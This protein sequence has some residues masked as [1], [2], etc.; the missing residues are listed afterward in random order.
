MMMASSYPDA[1]QEGIRQTDDL[2]TTTTTTTTPR[3]APHSAQTDIHNSTVQRDG[4]GINC[5]T[6]DREQPVTRPATCE[7]R[8]AGPGS[9]LRQLPP[10][11]IN[12]INLAPT[13]EESHQVKTHRHSASSH[14]SL[15]HPVATPIP[16]PIPSPSPSPSPI[17]IPIP[18]RSKS[19]S[20]PTTPLTARV[21]EG[22]YF[23]SNYYMTPRKPHFP[24]SSGGVSQRRDTRPT[25]DVDSSPPLAK[26]CS[27]GTS[28]NMRPGQDSLM[29][30]PTSPLSPIIPA[31]LVPS[32]HKTHAS[33][34]RT[35]R[36]PNLKLNSL[37][38]FHPA[39]FP[40]NDSSSASP[41]AS[42]RPPS[43]HYA[44]RPYSEAQAKLQQYQRE[45]ITSATRSS[46]PHISPS[47]GAKPS[48]PRLH[49]LG[50]PGPVT[51]MMLEG[52]GDYLIAGTG[53]SNGTMSSIGDGRE[54]VEKMIKQENERRQFPTR[55]ERI[56]PAVS[57]AGGRG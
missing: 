40:S 33:A 50:S 26:S 2:S 22:H 49:P 23:P 31:T 53:G 10:L 19:P 51:P 32:A 57:P 7:D 16:I 13:I 18:N 14:L 29:Y 30:T 41:R 9:R 1:S 5:A 54:M 20:P 28:S 36:A 21:N 55:E 37:P 6:T 34:R 27:P 24:A 45:I 47:T 56:S 8:Q 39:N 4:R 17:P 42:S 15:H 12:S 25:K 3:P 48:P 43:S 44:H 11:H 38:R 35:T 46:R 52:Q